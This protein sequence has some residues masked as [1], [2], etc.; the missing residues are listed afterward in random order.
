MNKL[1]K[2][3]YW[4]LITT[5]LFGW[6][7]LSCAMDAQGWHFID[8]FDLII[9]EA[10]HFIFIFFGQF[11]QILGGSL[12]QI[13]VPFIFAGYFFLRRD[14]FSTSLL[15]MF[16][17]YNIVNVSVYMGDSILMQLPLLGGDNVIHDWNYLLTSTHLLKYTQLLASTAWSLGV[18]IIIIGIV[19]GLKFSLN[20]KE[21][22]I[23][24]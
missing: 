10:G 8:N 7:F 3:N 11:I 19:L 5:I 2:L 13:L 24:E 15:L 12:I 6:Y 18:S 1:K 21:N 9:H 17:G 20:S 23:E 22:F 4:K 16:A 14:Y